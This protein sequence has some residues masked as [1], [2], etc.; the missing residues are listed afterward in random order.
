LGEIEDYKAI[1]KKDKSMKKIKVLFVYA[2]C[3]M[4]NLIPVGPSSLLGSLKESGLNIEIELFDTTFYK[5]ED[6][7]P[8]EDR[9]SNLQVLP[10]D[11]A[12]VDIAIKES[13]VFE[14]F[15]K[16]VIKFKPDIIMLSMVE[17]TYGQGMALLNCIKDIRPYVVAGGIFAML[18]PEEVISNECI[19]AVCVGEGEDAAVEFCGK[20]IEGKDFAKVPGMWF[21]ENGDIIK[22]QID[23]LIDLDK[24]A[25]MDFSL[26]ENERFYKPMQGKF[27]RMVPLEF[28]RGCPYRCAYCA[29]HALERHFHPVGKWYRW[30]SMG[31]IFAEIDK[32]L[33]TYK[34]EFF[35]FVSETFLSMSRERFDEF[36]KRYSNYK[37]PFWFNTRPETITKD[38]VKKL[39]DIGCF[40]VGIGLEHGNEEFRRTMLNR[41]VSSEKIIEACKIVEDSRI[42]YSVNNIIGFPGETRELVFDTIMLNRKIN[43]DTV[44]T[45]V[46]TPFKGTD[47]YDYCVKHGHIRA[48]SRV[49][50]LNRESV[51]ENN[52]LNKDEIR[53]LLRTFPL[54]VHFDEDMF[55]MIRKAEQLTDE[56]NRIFRELSERYVEEHFRKVGK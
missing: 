44:G 26:Y 27:F 4:D 49:G 43:P 41:R 7:P 11:Y 2:N 16:H 34:V 9:A 18:S 31:R 12:S 51:L 45:F 40:R 24:T 23:H 35:Y 48:G 56:G 6:R 20:F 29:N 54:Y 33:K 1:A 38:I 14:D 55:P 13:N 47:I 10:V 30:K 28:S 50:D 8:D 3:M 25:F 22:N 42:T 5:T 17:S 37:I 36:C 32:Y 15:R 52:T 19:D 53:G 46:L 39:E 21:K